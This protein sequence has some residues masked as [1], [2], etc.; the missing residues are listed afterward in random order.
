MEASKN[1]PFDL[2]QD[3]FM[4]GFS[5]QSINGGVK[6][7][8]R[9]VKWVAKQLIVNRN[10][11]VTNRYWPVR[12]CTKADFDKFS[13]PSNM[14]ANK[15]RKYKVSGGL[16][17]LADVDSELSLYSSWI[18]EDGYSSLEL[19]AVPCGTRI[20]GQPTREDCVWDKD[21]ILQYLGTLSLITVYNQG[22]F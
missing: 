14:L 15:F 9:Y 3:R 21:E 19:M 22:N 5:I 10:G 7:D 17:C 18:Y 1:N 12:N 8:E 6:N 20:E 11:D 13:E 16:Y 2:S 4:I